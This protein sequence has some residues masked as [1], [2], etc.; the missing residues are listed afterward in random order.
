[1][2][3]DSSILSDPVSPGKAEHANRKSSS[4]GKIYLIIFSKMNL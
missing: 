4:E 3:I 2:F 1:M